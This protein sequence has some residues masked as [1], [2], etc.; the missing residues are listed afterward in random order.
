MKHFVV[1]TIFIVILFAF[2]CTSKTGTPKF[3]VG[4]APL[5]DFRPYGI[6]SEKSY[7]IFHSQSYN[8]KCLPAS[9]Q[10]NAVYTYWFTKKQELTEGIAIDDKTF[11]NPK[12]SM[13]IYHVAGFPA[14]VVFIILN[15]AGYTGFINDADMTITKG[16]SVDET[17]PD[18]LQPDGITHFPPS[19][20][21]IRIVTFSFN[22]N[23]QLCNSGACIT[24]E[25]GDYI[26]AVDDSF[27]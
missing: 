10:C 19:G 25:S 15:G 5:G 26:T 11:P 1:I 2:N 4:Y 16:L 7:N 9:K 8:Q 23:V 14:W 21:Q 20:V 27:F 6:A 13:K 22:N 17:L 3:F 18:Y 24:I 12:F